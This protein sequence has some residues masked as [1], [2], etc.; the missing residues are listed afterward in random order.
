[1]KIYKMVFDEVEH[2]GDAE[3][4]RGDLVASGAKIISTEF[5]TCNETCTIIVEVEEPLKFKHKFF[6][7]NANEFF[8]GYSGT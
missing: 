3:Q 4:Y 6:K 1:M 7:T 8:I 2:D 5:N